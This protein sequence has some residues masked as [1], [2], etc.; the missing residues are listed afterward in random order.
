MAQTDFGAQLEKCGLKVTKQR[1]AVL[2][3]LE[4]SDAPLAADAVFL[5]LKSAAVPANLSTVYRALEVLTEKKLVEKLKL[6]DDPRTLYE[7]NRMVHKHNLICL[8]C[9]RVVAIR[10]CPLGDYEKALEKETDF[11]ISGHKLDIFGYCPECRKT[12]DKED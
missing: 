7:Y 10:H 5:A 1:K 4:E 2:E 6:Q 3:I 9:N 12:H 11:T 8:G